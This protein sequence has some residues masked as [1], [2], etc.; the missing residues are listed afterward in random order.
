[1]QKEGASAQKKERLKGDT[2]NHGN[3]IP[4][5]RYSSMG[6]AS[7]SPAIPKVG[8][9][10]RT[11]TGASAASFAL[12]MIGAGLL[13]LKTAQWRVRMHTNAQ[14][15]DVRGGAQFRVHRRL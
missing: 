4:A 2:H 3:W 5:K 13:H 6:V 11:A 9:C 15:P 14:L 12:I 8:Q 7:A 10:T 1:M